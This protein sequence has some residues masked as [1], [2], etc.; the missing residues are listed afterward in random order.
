MDESIEEIRD[1]KRRELAAQADGSATEDG[2]T[3][4]TDGTPTEPV[5][6]GSAD[7][8]GELTA[9]GEPVLVDF[10]ADWCGPCKQ[11]EPI[12]ERV[13]AETPATVATVDIDAH[14]GLAAEHGVR[15]VPTLVL[16]AGGEPVERVV[17]VQSADRLA[18][19][20]ERHA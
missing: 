2:G 20:V 12:V 18:G 5:Q 19:L 4:A 16:F 6:V 7:Q 9:G 8:L 10:Y 1:R 15:G 13:A 11:L 17:G 14:Q 3:D